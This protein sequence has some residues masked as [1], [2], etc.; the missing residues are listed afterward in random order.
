MK[1]T[2]LIIS[3]LFG[4][5]LTA[6]SGPDYEPQPV[7]T[8]MQGPTAAPSSPSPGITLDLPAGVRY[9]EP[10]EIDQY[11]PYP[12]DVIMQ[13]ALVN[14]NTVY[15]NLT[16]SSSCPSIPETVTAENGNLVITLVDWPG[17]CTADLGTSAWE[18]TL[19]EELVPPT[20][21]LQILIYS[22]SV[23]PAII[24][25]YPANTQNSMQSA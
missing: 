10:Q 12:N 5:I 2:I 11:M 7:P 22:G 6:C 9:L 16:G 8:D 13:A 24:E 1:K 3:L 4:L 25:A 15:I 19:P 17:N 21:P 14:E 20:E 23:D 18:I